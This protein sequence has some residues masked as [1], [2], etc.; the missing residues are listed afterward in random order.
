MTF[1]YE[2]P[3][4]FVDVET[5]GGVIG[6][7][8]LTEIAIIRYDGNEVST[9][10]TLINPTCHI[11]SFIENLTGISNTMVAKAPLFKEVAEQ[12]RDFLEG[13]IFVAHNVRFDYSL[14]KSE[15]KRIG[16]DFKSPKLCTVKLSRKLYPAY[17]RHGL[18]YL[19]Q[20]HHL[21][22]TNRH[23]AYGDAHV[24]LQFWQLV[25]QQFDGTYLQKRVQELMTIPNL[26]AH[27]DP[28]DIESIP[29]RL[30][31]YLLY[32]ENDDLLYVGKGYKLRQRVLSFFA[33]DRALPAEKSFSE[34]VVR[35]G[36]I[37]CAGELDALLTEERLID[38][39]KPEKNKPSKRAR[40]I[41]EL[42]EWPFKDYAILRENNL[43]HV[44]W[45]WHYLGTAHNTEELKLTVLQ[46]KQD[47]SHEIYKILV[48]NRERLVE[49]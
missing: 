26:P 22:I 24:L 29:N 25:N 10:Q 9:Y 3:F 33:K 4:A 31:V 36:Y 23:R 19:V 18:D 1:I 27:I 8:R 48:R 6:Q 38:Q 16:I 11:S 14:I 7:D 44:F 40:K 5:T 2:K 41:G 46:E 13:H 32:G 20:R 49:L 39:Y 12:I 34:R 17:E 30:G 37:E 42:E 35:V 21:Q 45:H 15:F 43:K 47:F 28:D